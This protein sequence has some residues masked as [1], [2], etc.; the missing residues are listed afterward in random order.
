MMIRNHKKTLAAVTA[1]SLAVV[2][3]VAIRTVCPPKS[4]KI[5][6]KD[7][8]TSQ[9]SEQRLPD[10]N[11][12]SP[13]LW[14]ALDL[15]SNSPATKKSLALILL[16][17]VGALITVAFRNLIGIR[18][19]GT[20]SPALLAISQ[21]KADWRVGVGVFV[22]T[23]G[24]GCLVRMFFLKRRLSA[25]ARRGIVA[26][27]V[28]VFLA[29]AIS[30]SERFR[31]ANNA[32]YVLLP[33]VVTTMM[34]ERFFIILEKQSRT[35]A[36]GVLINTLVAAIC[37]FAL[38]SITPIGPV[39]LAFPELELLIIAAL[40]LI[41]RYSGRSVIEIMGLVKSKPVDQDL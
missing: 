31:L 12:P 2:S 10:P 14:E 25:V 32:R 29:L 15:T 16:I 8:W 24:I 34:I 37:C 26:V 28:A 13:R 7:F 23:F 35:V 38:F 11:S 22:L 33:V 41:G 4:F 18:T 1:M 40:I 21:V 3:S 5:A 30:V 6:V 19:I 17:P 27:F 9:R 20:F 36:V 39:F